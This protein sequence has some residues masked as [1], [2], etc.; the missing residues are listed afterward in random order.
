MQYSIELIKTISYLLWPII[1]FFIVYMFR[2]EI[3][4]LL[5]NLVNKDNGFETIDHKPSESILPGSAP[6][7]IAR[8]QTPEVDEL[9]SD[10]QMKVKICRN[11]NSNRSFIL[12]AENHKKI[13]CITPECE[14]KW[15]DKDL[16]SD[17]ENVN[18]DV[19]K[20]DQLEKFYWW[21]QNSELSQP[22]PGNNSKMTISGYLPSYT[23]MLENPNTEPSRMLKYIKSKKE[24]SWL[25]TKK[26]LHNTYGYILS[27]GSMGASLKALEVLGHVRIVGQGDNKRITSVS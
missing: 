17:H 3:R 7:E 8:S 14:I 27:S 13:Y 26:Y 21:I 20:K 6:L 23:R 12:L 16:F 18:A 25:E 15:L 24:V 22:V 9:K 11:R 19:L 2:K 4:I 10:T 1:V 5:L